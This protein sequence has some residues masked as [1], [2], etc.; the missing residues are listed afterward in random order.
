MA[1]EMIT[2]L[3][4]LQSSANG[5]TWV[6][7][8][9]IIDYPDSGSDPESIDITDLS[10]WPNRRSMNGLQDSGNLAFTHNNTP[11][12]HTGLKTAAVAGEQWY[13]VAFGEDAKDGGYKW[14]G[15]LTYWH[16]GKGVN[17]ARGFNSSISV[18]STIEDLDPVVT[19]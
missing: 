5:T 8:A 10:D 14:Q 17:E 11:E 6:D 16:T 2:Q 3:T 15:S 9:R 13:R 4:Y 19:P 1:G 12:N 7:V 18:M